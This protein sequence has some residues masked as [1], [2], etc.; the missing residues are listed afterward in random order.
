M[1]QKIATVLIALGIFGLVIG[2]RV[3]ILEQWGAGLYSAGGLILLTIGVL[4]YW[5]SSRN[6]NNQSTSANREPFPSEDT[7]SRP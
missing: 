5:L 1:T 4:L 7:K 6:A 3:L 2:F